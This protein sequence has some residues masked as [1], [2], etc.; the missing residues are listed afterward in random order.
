MEKTRTFNA[1]DGDGN[2]A[3][4]V[5][6][7]K[8]SDTDMTRLGTELPLQRRFNIESGESLDPQEDGSFVGTETRKIFTLS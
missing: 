8:T 5:E 1:V 6:V 3:T 2:S 4:I 7:T